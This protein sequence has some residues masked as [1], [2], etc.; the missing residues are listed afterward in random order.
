M[1][2][3]VLLE[4]RPEG[5][6]LGSVAAIPGC[7]VEGRTR[8][9]TIA[10]VKVCLQERV[11]RLELTQV[12]A[13]PPTGGG[14]GNPWRDTAGWFADDPHLDEMVA[15]IYADRDAETGRDE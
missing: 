6:F 1:Q 8:E 3:T 5:G 7:T 11:R 12:E 10:G 4:E 14:N 9:E 15:Q 13:P 2:Y